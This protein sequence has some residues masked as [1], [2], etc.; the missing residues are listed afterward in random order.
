LR[1]PPALQVLGGDDWVGDCDD[2]ALVVGSADDAVSAPRVPQSPLAGGRSAS[3]GARQRDSAV[4][5]TPGTPAYTAPECTASG[6]FSGEAADVWCV[7][8]SA[9]AP[10]PA[11][12]R[13]CNAQ[14]QGVGGVAVCYADGGA[15]VRRRYAACH[16]RT[17]SRLSHLRSPNA[18]SFVVSALQLRVDLRGAAAAAAC[19]RLLAR[20]VAAAPAAP[21]APR[22]APALT[23]HPPARRSRRPAAPHAGEGPQQA[24]HAGRGP[25]APLV[26]ARSGCFAPGVR[27]S[28]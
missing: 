19:A 11:L 24:R 15:A 18:C 4:G 13:S 26:G 27:M 23:L 8:R 28:V 16:V 20:C 6:A 10:A 22:A 3:L 21:P 12:M 14:S 2:A 1:A 17:L 5:R 7:P 25:R 9:P